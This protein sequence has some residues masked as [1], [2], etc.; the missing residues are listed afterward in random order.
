[1]TIGKVRRAYFKPNV[2]KSACVH[3]YIQL[4]AVHTFVI[5]N[6]EKSQA[7]KVLEEA[8]ELTEAIKGGDHE[9]A[10][11]EAMDVHQALG[12]LIELMGWTDAQISSAYA[13]VKVRN[14][15]RGRYGDEA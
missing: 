10:L 15:Q 2:N 4:P 7:L 14:R 1:M 6:D 13:R 9:A 8:A 5:E 3:G 11:E 12:N